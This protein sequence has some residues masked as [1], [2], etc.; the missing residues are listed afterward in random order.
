[1]FDGSPPTK[2]IKK[3]TSEVDGSKTSNFLDDVSTERKKV[4]KIHN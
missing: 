2:K 4:S 1:M 3:V